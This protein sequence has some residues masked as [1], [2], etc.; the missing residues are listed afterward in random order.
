MLLTVFVFFV[1]FR[2]SQHLSIYKSDTK[3][4]VSSLLAINYLYKARTEE[5]SRQSC[6]IF[7][8]RNRRLIPLF[9][10]N[11]MAGSLKVFLEGSG[12]LNR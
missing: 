5:S 10:R 11:L 9:A 8:N 4:F 7:E 3:T 12:V 6:T 1:N 2:K